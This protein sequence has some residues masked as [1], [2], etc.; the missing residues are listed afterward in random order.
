MI[1]ICV[2][3]NEN[4]KELILR[5]RYGKGFPVD[6]KPAPFAWGG[7]CPPDF[8]IVRITDTDDV[9]DWNTPWT[10]ITAY[11]ILQHDPLAD[12]FRVKIFPTDKKSAA[13]LTVAE[14][15]QFLLDWG[16]EKIES[17]NPDLGVI[18]EITAMDAINHR[19]LFTFGAEDDFVTYSEIEYDMATGAHKV[20]MDYSLSKLTVDDIR[21]V[22][23]EAQMD[24]DSIE[25]VDELVESDDP[26]G[27]P[28]T[29]TREIGVC[30][31][32]GYRHKMIGLLEQQVAAKF[33]KMLTRVRWRFSDETVMD[34]LLHGGVKEMTLAEAEEDMI[35]VAEEV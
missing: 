8:A 7:A 27:E 13:A 35:D 9:K 33:H 28:T 30:I 31:F 12:F 15:Q 24:I 18:F 5:G 20:S 26:E 1:E 23:S 22:L 17:D 6:V 21:V 10:R 29:I 25:T 14:M 16:A 11:E 32:T 3:A 2:S 34:A 19:G 4:S